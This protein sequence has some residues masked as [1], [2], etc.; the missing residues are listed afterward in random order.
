[1][2]RKGYDRTEPRF[3][4]AYSIVIC[5]VDTAMPAFTGD[6]QRRVVARRTGKKRH[7]FTPTWRFNLL[8]GLA[9]DAAAE[10]M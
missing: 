7:I 5:L 3:S 6:A 2:F 9:K 10:F 1:M 8:W 4:V